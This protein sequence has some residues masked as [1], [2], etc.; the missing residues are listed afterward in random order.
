MKQYVEHASFN[1]RVP[2]SPKEQKVLVGYLYTFQEALSPMAL[3][4]CVIRTFCLVRS[5]HLSNPIQIFA[6]KENL[7]IFLKYNINVLSL[8][9]ESLAGETSNLFNRLDC[10]DKQSGRFIKVKLLFRER[11]TSTTVANLKDAS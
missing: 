10:F 3:V 2:T 1:F 4:S 9:V 6:L 8:T 11:Q 7:C 5:D